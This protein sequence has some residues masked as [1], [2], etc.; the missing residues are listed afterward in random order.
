M[1]TQLPGSSASYITSQESVIVPEWTRV[2]NDQFTAIPLRD[3]STGGLAHLTY[4]GA[5][6]AARA[7]GAELPTHDDIVA[8]S[9]AAR[10]AGFELDPVILPNGQL[11]S[12]GFKPGDPAMVS[13]RWA[14]IHDAAVQAQLD[15]RGWDG[16]S[17]V[18]NAGKH[19]IA[20]APPGRAY[21]MGWRR[22]DGT[23][24][25]SGTST[26]QGPHD[27]QHHDYATTTILVKRG[28]FA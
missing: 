8:L 1:A 22:R 19:W 28:L 24:I 10:S 23:F 11:T 26:G 6:E 12:E 13:L 17:P 3:A 7:A 9:N 4:A 5:L 21:L 14:Q 27:D 20:G 2:G 25:Q 15:R 18:S 16:K